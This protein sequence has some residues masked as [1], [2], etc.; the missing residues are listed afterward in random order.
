MCLLVKVIEQDY[1]LSGTGRWLKP[2]DGRSDPSSLV[3]DSEKGVF[4][5]NARGIYGDVMDWLTRVKSMS[6]SEARAYLRRVDP[7][8]FTYAFGVTPEQSTE[9]ITSEILVDSFWNK[10]KKN[11]GY[12]YK[13]LLTDSTIDR[14]KLGFHS[15]RYTIPIYDEGNLVNIQLRQDEPEKKIYQWYR[16][17]HATLF[18]SSIL[19]VTSSVV[20]C[21]GLVDAILLSQVGIPAIAPTIGAS[22]WLS[23]WNKKFLKINPVFVVYDNDSAGII[24]AKRVAE[25]LGVYKTRILTF[26]GMKEKY[27]VIDYFRDGGTARSFTDKIETESKYFFEL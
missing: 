8:D 25:N 10:G 23:S 6:P 3:V 4:F 27:D 14:F 22:A 24:G 18:N 2:R 19:E 7:S 1:E 17:T 5:W 26:E 11:R 21:E 20:I 15:G 13:R 12:W 16:G 9:I